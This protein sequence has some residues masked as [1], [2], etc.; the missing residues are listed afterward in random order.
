MFSKLLLYDIKWIIYWLL[1]SVY[2]FVCVWQG[3][4]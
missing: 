1:G 3:E 2:V 4:E